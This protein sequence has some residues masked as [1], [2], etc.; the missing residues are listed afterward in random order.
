PSLTA[1]LPV[2][3]GGPGDD[4]ALAAARL[5]A[6]RDAEAVG[7]AAGPAVPLR[8]VAHDCPACGA[9]SAG[10]APRLT[11]QADLDADGDVATVEV[12]ACA[13]VEPR[14]LLGA[15]PGGRYL[16]RGLGAAR[17]A[18]DRGAAPAHA[19]GPAAPRPAPPAPR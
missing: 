1:A 9:R 8:V 15:E 4:T 16:S 13:V 18:A 5:L 6:E 11:A 2:W 3:D 7:R 12:L 17:C 10:A 19:P 14:G